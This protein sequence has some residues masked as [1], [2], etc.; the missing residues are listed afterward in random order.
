M[1]ISVYTNKGTGGSDH[2]RTVSEMGKRPWEW[3][4]D[5]LGTVYG[6]PSPPPPFAPTP[7]SSPVMQRC[8]MVAGSQGVL[9][10]FS[11]K[12]Q[13]LLCD[14]IEVFQ[15]TPT[16]KFSTTQFTCAVAPSR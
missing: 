12:A 7:Q 6:S 3:D 10:S 15:D 13:W 4:S 14:M 9:V 5:G 1:R 11:N 2:F 16:R 8:L